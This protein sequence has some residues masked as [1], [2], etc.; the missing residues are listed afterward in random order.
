M[1]CFHMLE[2]NLLNL[3]HQ[4]VCEGSIIP[5]IGV[6][7]YIK[8]YIYMHI[9]IYTFISIYAHFCMYVNIMYCNTGSILH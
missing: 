5:F 6:H 3:G 2:F 8:H 9:D 7:M 4:L 1:I